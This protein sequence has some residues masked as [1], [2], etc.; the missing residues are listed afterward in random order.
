LSV[1]RSSVEV[2]AGV[3]WPVSELDNYELLGHAA[4]V[5]SLAVIQRL[6]AQLDAREQVLLHAMHADPVPN[7]DG[8]AAVDK[9][10]VREDV[11]CAKRVS[12]QTAGLRLHNATELV[13]R[14][15]ATLALLGEG[16]IS[17]Q[18][19]N[20]LVEAVRGLPEQ[21][22]GRV[23]A[24]TVPQFAASVQR[25]VMA[26][27]PRSRDE[28]VEDALGQRRVVFSPQDDG[29]TELW[30]LLGADTAAAI[31]DA[32][33]QSA[34]RLKRRDAEIGCPR[35]ADQRR[36]DALAELVLGGGPGLRPR[37]NVTVA[38]STLL[39]LDEQAGELDGHGPIPA[40]LARA[41]AFDP[42]GRWRRLLTD[43]HGRLVQVSARTYRPPAAMARHVRAQNVTCVFP[44]CRRRA[45]RCELDH[46][47]AWHQCQVTHPDNLQPLC[48]RHHHLKHETTWQVHRQPDNT[49]TWTA[50]SGHTYARPPDELPRDTTNRQP[51]QPAHD[52]DPPPF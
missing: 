16:G 8:S 18:H 43:E 27:D 12:P 28:Q 33:D 31:R 48:A 1:V 4:R 37:V 45:V 6:R 49:T 34:E 39:N 11:A 17:L 32:V 51:P 25:A 52:N 35:T 24:Q 19:A 5:E 21:V 2:V 10:W 13:T 9:Q 46:V 23:E 29:T 47:I 44:G 38:L 15:P 41:L 20:R 3:A 7:I 26:L 22:V 36:A 50:P 42:T 30:A 40:V 14:L